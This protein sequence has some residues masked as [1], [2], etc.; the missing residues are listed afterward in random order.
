[1][2]TFLIIFLF[3]FLYYLTKKSKNVEDISQN[4]LE[5]KIASLTNKEINIPIENASNNE[6]LKVEIKDNSIDVSRIIEYT[7]NIGKTFQWY[8]QNFYQFIGQE[9]AKEQAKTIIAKMKKGIKCHSILSAIQGHGK[10]T[11][12]RLLAKELK[13]HLIER[14]GKQL[15]T[16]TLVDIVNEITTSKEDNVI[17]FLDEIDTADWKTLKLLNPILQDF[18]I[19]GKRIRPFMFCS[20]TINKDLLIRQTPDLLDRIQHQIQFKRY[21]NEEIMS[22]LKQYKQELYS[23]EIVSDE[24]LLVIARNCKYNPRLCLGILEDYIITKDIYKTLKDRR[25]IKEGLTDID[26]KILEVLSQSSRAIGANALSQRIGLSQNQYVR[27][28]EPYLC[29]F[30]Y[31][32]RVPSRMITDKGREI[33]KELRDK[34]LIKG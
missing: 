8:P 14:V 22:I 6:N 2:L 24:V 12:I 13:A 23:Q 19:S 27:E 33:L 34:T 10:S 16:Y 9:E 29:E 3:C 31:I 4:N 11:F 18:Q 17:F 30:N 7:G 1:M 25:I 26:I 15:D 21:N 5:I 20:A 28:F 32:V